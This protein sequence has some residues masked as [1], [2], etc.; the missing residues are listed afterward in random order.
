MSK[1]WWGFWNLLKLWLSP[2]LLCSQELNQ[3]SQLRRSENDQWYLF[4]WLCMGYAA[5]RITTGRAL[6]YNQKWSYANSHQ[7]GSKSLKSFFVLHQGWNFF[8][9]FSFGQEGGCQKILHY[10]KGYEKL[11]SFQKYPLS[12]FP[13]LCGIH[14]ERSLTSNFFHAILVISLFICFIVF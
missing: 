2:K 9:L 3:L 14:N 13:S 7:V 1:R 10:V 8:L 11:R 6:L 4:C 12:P 5:T